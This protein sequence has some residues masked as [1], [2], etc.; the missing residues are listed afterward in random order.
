MEKAAEGGRHGRA[1]LMN[2]LGRGD[3]GGEGG[4]ENNK[5]GVGKPKPQPKKSAAAQK[6]KT[7]KPSTN[8]TSSTSPSSSSS[9]GIADDRH[10]SSRTAVVE[11]EHAF[12]AGVQRQAAEK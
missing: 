3:D 6:K 9:I 1:D 10:K 4:Q 7:A 8:P 5:R 11:K 2:R 12:S